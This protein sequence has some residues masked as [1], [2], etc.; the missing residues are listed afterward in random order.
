MAEAQDELYGQLH[1]TDE[2][3]AHRTEAMKQRDRAKR[4]A[5]MQRPQGVVHQHA[6]VDNRSQHMAKGPKRERE[7]LAISLGKYDKRGIAKVR[8]REPQRQEPKITLSDMLSDRDVAKL[9]GLKSR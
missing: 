6:R 5:Q 7:D 3:R 9:R 2:Q 8:G 1:L 4:D